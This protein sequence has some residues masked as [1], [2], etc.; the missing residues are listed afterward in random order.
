MKKLLLL[1]TFFLI[2]HQLQADSTY[3]VSL[4]WHGFKSVC[5]WPTSARAGGQTLVSYQKNNKSELLNF[6]RVA[7]SD[8]A[9]AEEDEN[10]Y[11]E[12][13]L[14]ILFSRSD[15]TYKI[16]TIDHYRFYLEIFTK[17]DFSRK[18]LFFKN[19]KTVRELYRI[20]FKDFPMP[21]PR[22]RNFPALRRVNID[23]PRASYFRIRD[24]SVTMKDKRL[25]SPEVVASLTI[26][27]YEFLKYMKFKMRTVEYF[28]YK[29]TSNV[30]I[31]Y[32]SLPGIKGSWH[33]SYQGQLFF[34]DELQKLRYFIDF[35]PDEEIFFLDLFLNFIRLSG[36]TPSLHLH[37]AI[38]Y[39]S[40][41]YENI[42]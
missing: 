35:E 38:M 7:L 33:Y 25:T 10:V 30:L 42:Y 20:I 27:H 36:C 12:K 18:V 29:N 22:H 21:Q 6:L 5:N 39:N 23:S 4:E 16:K 3:H 13:R 2:Q 34:I 37:G 15:T 31:F 9:G 8:T 14:I 32:T 28:D 24:A 40:F 11:P 17:D 41:F 26:E 19:I 1:A